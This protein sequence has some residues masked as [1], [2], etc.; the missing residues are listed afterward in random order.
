MAK[1]NVTDAAEA[2]GISRTTFYRHLE[3]KDIAY[4][5]DENGH[6]L[7]DTSELIRVY[8][9]LHP[10]GDP[11]NVNRD[12]VA[13]GAD[14][15]DSAELQLLQQRVQHLEEQRDSER[16]R[17]EQAEEREQEA[18]AEA[19]RLIGIVEKQTLL[20]NPPQ[21]DAGDSE[22]EPS[23]GTRPAGFFQRMFGSDH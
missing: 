20:L 23:Q 21:Q 13:Q 9:A 10:P 22:P 8:G 18:R 19:A 1:L 4:D 14:G 16:E 6:K 3:S 5:M 7:F 17:R 15:V 12:A 11:E 2:V